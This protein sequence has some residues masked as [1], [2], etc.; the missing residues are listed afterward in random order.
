M[1]VPTKYKL[2]LQSRRL[3]RLNERAASV[4]EAM[5]FG[6]SLHLEHRRTAARWWLSNGSEINA[7]IA[8]L[9]TKHRTSLTAATVCGVSR[10]RR[11]TDLSKINLTPQNRRSIRCQHQ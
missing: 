3:D 5:G 1:P 4:L 10:T 9:V 7:E 6:S 11:L 8:Q 2:A